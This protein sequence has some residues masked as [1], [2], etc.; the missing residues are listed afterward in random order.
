ME[1]K[2]KEFMVEQNTDLKKK[3]A[4]NELKKI[5]PLAL[6][7]QLACDEYRIQ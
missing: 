5:Q 7:G 1:I 3:K 4:M 2:H 6:L